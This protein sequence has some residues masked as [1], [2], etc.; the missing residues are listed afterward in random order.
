MGQVTGGR[1]ERRHVAGRTPAPAPADQARCWVDQTCSEQGLPSKVTDE[2]VLRDV[3]V[4]LVAGA[5]GG[6]DSDPPVR[7]YPRRV[8]HVA[9][10]DPGTNDDGLEESGDDRSLPGGGEGVPLAS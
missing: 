4:L 9:A 8:E 1:T 2:A 10:S 7:R 3:A 6:L 5:D